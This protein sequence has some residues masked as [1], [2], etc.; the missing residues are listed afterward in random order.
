MTIKIILCGDGAVGKTAIKLRYLGQGFK[1]TYLA[2][3]GADFAVKRI[4]LSEDVVVKAQI[5][6]LAGQPQFKKVRA[7][8]Y[9]GAHAIIVIFDISRLQTYENICNWLREI[10]NIVSNE[11]PVVLVGN[12]IDLRGTGE[13]IITTEVG[14]ELTQTISR[15]LFNSKYVV[16]YIECSAKTGN[17][18]EEV[19][20]AAAAQAIC[21]KTERPIWEDGKNL[22]K[23]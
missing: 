16:P 17:N 13:E 20:W 9:R 15:E 18:V 10:Y 4:D 2:T 21:N 8:Y 1:S 7:G 14:E 23:V 11:V 22:A 5:W 19:F 6:D 12:K 3:V